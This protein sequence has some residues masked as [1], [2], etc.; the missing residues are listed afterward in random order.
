MALVNALT[1]LP[2]LV[3]TTIDFS[4]PSEPLTSFVVELLLANCKNLIR[5]DASDVLTKGN[6]LYEEQYKERLE[7]RRDKKEDEFLD[8]LIR[9]E[10]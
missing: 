2:Q 8:T 1:S 6:N 5:T 4:L 9:L 3:D 7:R 10:F